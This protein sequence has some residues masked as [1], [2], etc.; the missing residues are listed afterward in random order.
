[1]N[2]L[3]MCAQASRTTG[4]KP[5]QLHRAYQDDNGNLAYPMGFHLPAR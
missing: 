4:L 2:G 1:M 5:R 3:N